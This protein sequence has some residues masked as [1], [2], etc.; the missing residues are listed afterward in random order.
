MIHKTWNVR[1]QTREELIS[2]A[3]NL[4]KEIERSFK[5]LKK[6]SNPEDAKRMIDNIWGM[7]AWANEI[8]I[9][10]LRREY[11]KYGISEEN[12]TEP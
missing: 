8:Q 11:N 12:E 10:L 3:E 9:E 6:L 2:K 1:D 4:Y 7:K 5:L